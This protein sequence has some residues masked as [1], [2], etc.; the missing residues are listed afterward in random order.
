MAFREGS[1]GG[2]TGR[3]TKVDLGAA[4]VE[5][6]VVFGWVMG[7]FVLIAADVMYGRIV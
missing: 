4:V 7:V 1:L 6:I 5:D 2:I 3:P